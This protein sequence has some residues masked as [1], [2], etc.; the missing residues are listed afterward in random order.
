MSKPVS[1]LRGPRALSLAAGI[2]L[3]TCWAA[4]LAG[5]AKALPPNC[6]QAGNGVTCTFSSTGAEQSFTVPGGVG[7]LHVVAVGAKG[8]KGADFNAFVGGTGGLGAR[9]E[10]DLAVTPGKVLFIEVGGNGGDGSHAVSGAGGFNGGGST[11][12]NGLLPGGGGGGATDIRT[13]SMLAASCTNAANTL[14]SRLLVA[15]GGGGGGS[16]GEGNL[17]AGTGG[18]GGAAGASG[19]AGSTDGCG[20]GTPGGGGGAGTQTA[21]GAGGTAGSANG[22]PAGN[23]GVLGQGGD[24]PSSG[25]TAEPAGGGGGGYFGGGAGGS[26]NGCNAG[27]GGGGSSLVPSNGSIST[28]TT[29]VPELV[30]SYSVAQDA[31]V[32]TSAAP[33]NATA[34]YPALLTSTVTN[35]GPDTGPITFKDSVPAGLTI[36]SVGAGSGTCTTSGQQVTCTITGLGVG[37][38]ALVDIAVTPTAA[39]N[40]TNAVSVSD[41]PGFTDSNSGNNS[42][43]AALPVGVAHS[44]NCVVPKLKGFRV[45]FAKQ[46]LHLLGCT[47]RVK[48][49][50]SNSVHKGDAVRTKPGKGTYAFGKK[51][52]IIASSGPKKK[53]H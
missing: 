11:R 29:G 15:A 31:G 18:G 35:G 20:T 52:T 48:H 7:S 37:Q 16:I 33:S 53:H 30:I 17:G 9:L 14:N 13:C 6:T 5:S 8:G 46:L 26:G 23:P 32:S 49:A 39:G 2:A 36:N 4:A 50:H 27:G 40:Y 10:G 41:A 22:A 51:V 1:V 21:G 28:D 19:Q 38:S 47:T 34:G 3:A 45:A 12:T 42:A 44:P 43:S 24:V 25:A